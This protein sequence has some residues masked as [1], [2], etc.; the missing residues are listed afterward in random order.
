[1]GRGERPEWEEPEGSLPMPPL[2]IESILRLLLDHSVE[3]IVIGGF[4]LSVHGIVRATK[5]IDIVP[6]PSGANLRRLAGALAEL[7]AE[8]LLADDFSAG[9]LGIRPDEQGLALG[10]NWVLRTRFGRL[11]VMQ[12]VE[13]AADY[14]GLRQRAVSAEVPNAGDCLFASLDDLIAMKLAAGRP[15]DRIDVASLERART[16]G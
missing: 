10:G 15:Q 11:D 4:S 9:E 6:A 12:A 5:D 16:G 3:F 14:A 13:G 1:M 7:D 8:P 2:Q